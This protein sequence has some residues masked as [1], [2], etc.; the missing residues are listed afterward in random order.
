[1]WPAN[2]YEQTAAPYNREKNCAEDFPSSPKKLQCRDRRTHQPRSLPL[3]PDV[4]EILEWCVDN[5][6]VLSIC[7]R[8][9]DKALVERILRA[10]GIWDWFLLPQIYYARSK[11]YHFRNLSD[12]T[13]LN[14]NS[15]LFFDDDHANIK[16]CTTLGVTA[17]KVDK[18]N[19]LTWSVFLSGLQSFQSKQKS[20]CM[21][22]QWLQP[23]ENLCNDPVQKVN[24][25]GLP[26]Q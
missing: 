3:Y 23:K 8:S 13:D 25:E 11:T 17:C 15:F 18:E 26:L 16:S 9:P 12:V 21:M 19:G 6:I 22:N 20:Q 7:S 24:N 5:N 10:F 1:M 2:C 4:R 14:Y